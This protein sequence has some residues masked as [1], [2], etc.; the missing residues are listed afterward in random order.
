MVTRSKENSNISGNKLA[1]VKILTHNSNE[2]TLSSTEVKF[3]SNP[4][5]MTTE[6]QIEVIS[7][8]KVLINVSGA[9]YHHHQ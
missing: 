7:Y 3:L 5:V 4:M 8:Q 1:S 9:H 6:N 2:P